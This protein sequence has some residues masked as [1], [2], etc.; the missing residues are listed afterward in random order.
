MML[1]GHLL[2][3]I[4]CDD[5]EWFYQCASIAIDAL[6]RNWGSSQYEQGLQMDSSKIKNT[7]ALLHLLQYLDQMKPCTAIL[8]VKNDTYQCLQTRAL[9]DHH[10]CIVKSK[11]KIL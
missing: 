3:S 8:K 2:K 9:H 11:Y 5:V 6:A 7:P 4:W 1:S 10:R